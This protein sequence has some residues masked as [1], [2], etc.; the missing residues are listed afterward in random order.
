MNQIIAVKSG[1]LHWQFF[2]DVTYSYEAAEA[3]VYNLKTNGFKWRIPHLVE[4]QEFRKFYI[5]LETLRSPFAGVTLRYYFSDYYDTTAKSIYCYDIKSAISMPGATQAY[6]AAVSD[7]LPFSSR[8]K[9]VYVVK[10]K[11]EFF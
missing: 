3:F 9:S 6:L 1:N 11:F 8:I 2:N 4:L 5:S 10:D 7:G